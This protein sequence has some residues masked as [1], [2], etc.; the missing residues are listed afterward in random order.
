V[1]QRSSRVDIHFLLAA[2]SLHRVRHRSSRVAVASLGLLGAAAAILFSA[3]CVFF[4][5][6]TE[7]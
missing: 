1:R 2:A 7:I 3:V 4:M 5:F 6:S